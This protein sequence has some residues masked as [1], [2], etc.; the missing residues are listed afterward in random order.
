MLAKTSFGDVTIRPLAEDFQKLGL[1]RTPGLAEQA[2]K[3]SVV[4][5]IDFNSK[6]LVGKT[7]LVWKPQIE[8]KSGVLA[9]HIMIQEQQLTV[10][11]DDDNDNRLSVVKP[12]KDCR[13]DLSHGD[14]DNPF[15]NVFPEDLYYED[16][17]NCYANFRVG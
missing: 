4:S 5:V 9:I 1:F 10:E 2:N 15:F 16:E 12:L 11:Y 6:G 13:V 3:G 8:F 7:R 14:L 17:S